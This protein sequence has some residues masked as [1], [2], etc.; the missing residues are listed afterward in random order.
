MGLGGTST[1]SGGGLQLGGLGTGTGLGLGQSGGLG[2]GTGL[3]LG[4]LGTSQ[5]TCVL[6]C[7]EN[8]GLKDCKEIPVPD[9]ELVMTGYLFS[10]MFL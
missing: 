1:A 7:M 4:G 10:S 8:V 2:T 9:K 6:K 5:G 3:S